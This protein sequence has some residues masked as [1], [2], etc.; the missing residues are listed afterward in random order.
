[1]ATVR[2]VGWNLGTWRELGGGTAD[3]LR[4]PGQLRK[5]HQLGAKADANAKQ[6]QDM[7]EHMVGPITNPRDLRRIKAGGR[8]GAGL[9]PEEA[10]L[11]SRTAYVMALIF[12][13]ALA[14]AVIQKLRTGKNPE[15]TKDLFYPQ[16][17]TTDELGNPNREQLPSY[18]KDVLAYARHPFTTISHKLHP[19]LQLGA[20][21]MSN[22][23]FFGDRIYDPHAPALQ[24]VK[25]IFDYLLAQSH[26]FSVTNYQEEQKRGEGKSPLPPLFGLTPAPREVVRTEA[27]N[28]M[29]EFLARRRVR[30]R[31]P[32]EKQEAMARTD[33]TRQLQRS[34]DPS[35][36]RDM[37]NRGEL[38]TRQF[39]GALQ[40][41]R[42]GNLISM[43]DQLTIDEAQ[44]VFA[45]ATP[46][47]KQALGPS[48]MR[49]R[50][51]ALK[52]GRRV[53][54]Q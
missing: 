25:E 15:S 40:K 35:G 20:D 50:I 30:D 28:L 33:A 6:I 32:E 14:G 8:V 51:N 7:M 4:L 13:T 12:G 17:G 42:K 10:E 54:G 47:E 11:T 43:F 36:L 21:L 1:M 18:T 24:R 16:T 34:G 27:Q 19:E 41:S 45:K 53:A 29:A 22:E 49:K 31:T 9:S 37:V 3:A 5:E 46:E 39:Q 44:Q 38:S 23:D 2:S 52:A 26:P 48:L